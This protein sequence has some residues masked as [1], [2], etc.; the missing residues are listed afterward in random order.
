MEGKRPACVRRVEAPSA[1]PRVNQTRGKLYLSTWW[2]YT[3]EHVRKFRCTVQRNHTIYYVAVVVVVP[4]LLRGGAANC[5][6]S[7]VFR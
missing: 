1:A 2:Y 4:H 7:T 5:V 6:M 3:Q